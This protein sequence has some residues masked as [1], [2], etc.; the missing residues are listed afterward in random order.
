MTGMQFRK[1][2][3]VLAVQR[4]ITIGTKRRN[5]SSHGNLLYMAAKQRF[6]S[7]KKEDVIGGLN[8]VSEFTLSKTEEDALVQKSASIAIMQKEAKMFRTRVILGAGYLSRDSHS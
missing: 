3:M 6:S 5:I 8:N 2:H 4:A 7:M 1:Q